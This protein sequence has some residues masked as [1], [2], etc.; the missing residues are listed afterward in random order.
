MAN[1]NEILCTSSFKL[2]NGQTAIHS[3]TSCILM[4]AEYKVSL[5]ITLVKTLFL[6][7]LFVWLRQ[8]TLQI[9]IRNR[10][11]FGANAEYLKCEYFFLQKYFHFH[12]I[13][14]TRAI[15][16]CNIDVANFS[17]AQLVA[18]FNISICCTTT[19]NQSHSCVLRSHIQFN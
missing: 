2:K 17:H 8:I 16:P 18:K 3:D 5:G 12:A 4:G 7:L 15:N 6:L 10:F 13:V 9:G 11:V 14:P 19:C 1:Q